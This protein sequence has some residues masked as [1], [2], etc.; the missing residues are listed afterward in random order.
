MKI[1]LASGSKARG[2]LL[3]TIGIEN[4]DV[5]VTD[6]DETPLK[7]EKPRDLAKRLAISKAEKALESFS[8][9][10]LII[11]ADT[12]VGLG[13]RS[14]GKAESK[15]DIINFLNLLSGRRHNLYT[16]ICVSCAKTALIK[17]RV[18]KTIIKVKRLTKEEIEW[19]AATGEGIG[20]AGGYSI[21][22]KFQMFCP[23]VMGQTSN[24]IGLPLFEL[25]NMLESCGYKINNYK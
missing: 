19:Y 13:A 4:F 22:Q 20:N 15:E 2:M 9:D 7:S 11:T 10:E 14:L 12:V 8:A 16:G 1:I 21:G 18:V 23:E 17:T 3:K 6:I 5:F 24:V 25:K